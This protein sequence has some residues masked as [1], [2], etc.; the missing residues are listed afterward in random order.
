[1]KRIHV[2]VQD[3]ESEIVN[4]RDMPDICMQHLLAVMLID[5]GLTFD[6]SHDDARMHD[7]AVL[8][9]RKRI[10]YEGSAALSKAGGRQAILEV[11]TTDGRTLRHHT[12]VVRGTWQT[13]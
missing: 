11:E 4:N 7:L 10:V 2:Q 6:S 13:R 9:V 5:S 1:V 3:T 8:A 12:E